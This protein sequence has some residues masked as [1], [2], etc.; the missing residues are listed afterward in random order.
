MPLYL[1]ERVID[2]YILSPRNFLRFSDV[3]VPRMSRVVEEA[4]EVEIVSR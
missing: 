2:L 1:L 4:S 3:C